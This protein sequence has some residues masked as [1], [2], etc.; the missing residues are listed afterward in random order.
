[1]AIKM[2][3]SQK[4]KYK[5]EGYGKQWDPTTSIRAYFIGLDKFQ[6]SLADRSIVSSI[7]EMTMVAGARMWESKMFTKDQMVAWKNKTPVQQTRQNLQDYF[8]EKWLDQTQYLQATVKQSWFKDAA[9]AAQELSAVEEEGKTTAM[10]FSL[11][12]EQHKAQLEAIAAANKQSMDAM[13]EHMNVL[14]TGQSK[15]ADKT[16]AAI[17]NSNTGQASNTT[18]QK[19][20]YA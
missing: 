20:K 8:A 14:I 12:Q 15:V 18:N 5:A 2:T 4:F 13:L 9:L 6:T 1:M 11:L 16:T 10:M 7:K 19:K 3:T 17:P